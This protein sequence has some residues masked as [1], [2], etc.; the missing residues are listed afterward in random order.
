MLA[1]GAAIGTALTTCKLEPGGNC[2]RSG[3][4]AERAFDRAY[5]HLARAVTLP[6][7]TMEGLS[8]KARAVPFIFQDNDGGALNDVHEAFIRS[9][10]DDAKRLAEQAIA[11]IAAAV[12]GG[13]K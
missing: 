5:G 9:L 8:A 10:A 12:K 7:Q 2:D 11:A 1:Y 4:I 13:A 6:A 3:P